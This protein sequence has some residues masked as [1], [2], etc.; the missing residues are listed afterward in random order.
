MPGL[1]TP[2][3]QD[4]TRRNS[5]AKSALRKTFISKWQT[6][7]R[8]PVSIIQMNIMKKN[9]IF[10]AALSLCLPAT[11]QRLMENLNRSLVTIKTSNGVYASWRIHG[12]EYYDTQYNLYRDGT[13]VN[14]T[15]LD[16]SNFTDPDGTISSTYTVRAV[17][18]GV[19]QA[20]CQPAQV[21]QQQYL[22]I[23][24]GRMYSHN[25]TDITQDYSLND[26]TAADLDGDGEYELI[27]KRIYNHDGLF[28]AS[29][30]TAYTWFEAYKLDGTRLWGIEV[31]PN[32]VSSSHVETN[33]TAFDWDEDGKA[34][35]LMRA[36]D[37]TVVYASDGTK[38]V[39]GDPTKNYRN[40]VVH[41]GN[42]TYSVAGDEYLIY[43]E[44]ATAKL[45]NEPMEFPLK[46]LED[47]E[48]DLEAVW[49]DSYGH[50]ANKFF[51]GAPYLD[52]RKPS[53]FLARGIY[54][55]HKMIAYDVNPQT[56]EL[57]ERWQ[58]NCYDG[59]SPWFGQGYHN[60]GIADVDWDGRDEIVYGS[61]VIDDNGHGLSTT[62]YGH[63]DAQHCS[64]FDPYRKGQEIFAC[65]ENRQ[66][67]NYRD[68]TTSRI[69]YWYQHPQDCGRCMAGK[70]TENIPGSQVVAGSSGIVSTV[71][72]KAAP[73]ENG[74]IG[75]NFRIYWDGD[76]CSESLDGQ[77]TE[78]PA[79]IT[80]YDNQAFVATGTKTNNWTK[81]NP[82]LTADLL[83]DWREEI[84]VRREDDQALRIYTTTEPTPWRNYTLM[85]DMQYRQ[86]I[87]WQM[88]GYNQPPHVSYF[89][90][91]AEGYTVTPPPLMSNGRTEA[92]DAITT[93]HNGQ[94]VLLADPDGGE[95]TVTDGVSPY[96]L[97]VNAFSHTE[98]HDDNDNITTTRATYTL[99][100]GTFTGGMRLVKQGEG[101]LTLSGNQTYSGPTELWGGT[102][103]FEG[104]LPD[105][106]V[107]LNRFAELNA[108][109][110][111]GR[112]IR[113][114]Y[115]SVLRV[116]GTD[117][118]TTQADSLSLRY[119]A[120]V[121]FDLQSDGLQADRLSLTKGLSLENVSQTY[122]PEYQS[123]IFRFVPHSKA[124]EDRL[125][126]G[127]YLIADVKEIDGDLTKII[128][129]G[130]EDYD[131]R[132]E[133]DGSHLYLNVKDMREATQ[134]YWN[135][136]QE[137]NE[138]N[139]NE[140]Q[141][142]SNAGE[143][144]VFATGDEVIFDDAAPYTTVRLTETLYPSQV[145]FDNE[146][147]PYSLSGNGSISGTT[148]LTKTGGGSLTIATVNA[149]TGK[150]VLAG[151]TTTVGAL[152]NN[153]DREGALGVY[154][155]ETDRLEIRGGATLR[156]T[157]AVTCGN[158][159]TL[160]D[161]GGTLQTDANLTLETGLLSDGNT[162]VKSGTA[163][164]FVPA[165]TG[166]A[167]TILTGGTLQATG[168]G[169]T[170][171]DTLVIAGNATYQDKDDG[172][173]YSLNT[174]NIKV[175]EGVTA[176]L[177]C[178]SR[179]EM[180]TR[181]FGK[182]T[183]RVYV[184]WVRTDFTGDWSAFEGT[185]EP[186]NP[187]QWF[188]LNNSY[189]I[190]KA[191]LN[192]PE[193]ITVSNTA[194]TYAI[195]S[196]T[197]SG[198]LTGDN[199]TWRVGTLN[200]DFTFAGHIEG[201]GTQLIKAGSGRMTVNG[202][203][204][205]T[206]NCT[207]QQ[208]TLCLSNSTAETGMLGTGNVT[209]QQGATLC[210]RGKLD[211]GNTTVEKDGLLYP[212]TTE[213]AISGTIDFSDNP[214]NIEQGGTLSLN[215][216]SNSRCTSLTGITTLYLR[217]TLR[218]GIRDGLTLKTG[219]EYKL[220]DANRT[221]LFATAV[222]DLESP[223]EGLEWDTADLTDGI[224]RVQKATGV[225]SVSNEAEVQCEIFS[226]GGAHVGS[227]NC[228]AGSIRH[229][230]EQSGAAPGTYLVKAI[231]GQQVRTLKLTVD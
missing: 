24:M 173:S 26:A 1:P 144:D 149:Y 69:Y 206:G 159:I 165:A 62:G 13:L 17:V 60:Y 4:Y 103:N 90:G 21:W 70:F 196:L 22:E 78:G 76:L 9:L 133:H 102:V 230:L 34:E 75:T 15:P 111:F 195:G 83:G 199:N 207:V 139:L 93:A 107:W 186:T 194:K 104:Q 154:S 66:G 191:T 96:I 141:N 89:M 231:R 193:G 8:L 150:T 100:G 126:T 53:I 55:R 225:N 31:G 221:R 48:T 227:F 5:C 16:V 116:G 174:N 140:N 168:E 28:E 145:T 19:E 135:G 134:V 169:V 217:G 124:G 108:K 59:S 85:H 163:T 189:G 179:C 166:L 65:N 223:G 161:G 51:F 220:W 33:I 77:G 58:W 216:V 84:I 37:G 45:Y 156:N 61:M 202:A 36:A 95:V 205:F 119:G 30:D 143:T 118:G 97:T 82:S 7:K 164:L 209:V 201:T 114:E 18:R 56:H 117:I 137:L 52:G 187:N 160:G 181:L 200:S 132:L 122:G 192:L 44:G 151:G 23:P 2:D 32:I 12:T 87:A 73:T 224:L 188:G 54:T 212:G 14:S 113:M 64:D 40:Q 184:P 98:G 167:K 131:C 3:A 171:G 67:A 88:C 92:T 157:E 172:N 81:N 35:V 27:V 11:G 152:A 105:S 41:S 38:Q 49:G 147:K 112:D 213:Q 136:T 79:T 99:T 130:L 120:I 127:K 74:F 155:T 229:A 175:E 128:L 211:N 177:N 91:E 47:G 162:L 6:E 215:I 121:E 180:R 94:H 214:L 219:T 68:A 218:V 20:D 148:G 25:G 170:F 72:G 183:L 204:T 226:T 129:Q 178:D 146:T 158:T 46:R 50:R 125:A 222:L 198:T 228:P 210:G 39:I 106:R 123:P 208:G 29:T 80:T 63:G 197:G 109:A 101:T 42:M 43:M 185:L 115:A 153:I 176:T 86:A 10:L 203:H 71:T 190:P 138:W 142:F 182:G 110:V 57:T